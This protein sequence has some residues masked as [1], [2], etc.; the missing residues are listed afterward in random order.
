MVEKPKEIKHE[1][2]VKH[3]AKKPKK[4]RKKAAKVVIVRGKRKRAIARATVKPGTGIVRVN[5]VLVDAID[6][7]LM[8][9]TIKEPL[10]LAPGVSSKLDINVNVKGGGPM[11]QAEAARNAIAVG[12]CTFTG[13]EALKAQ[14]MEHDKYLLI[15]D[16]RRIEPKKY[17]GPKA[18]A[19]KQK[20]Y[21]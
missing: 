12:M 14:F 18:R 6:N 16:A 1:K 10:L 3:E 2:E 21:R 15:E 7:P 17:M 20:S 9:E 13:D 19:R 5:T 11:G 8:R 4:S